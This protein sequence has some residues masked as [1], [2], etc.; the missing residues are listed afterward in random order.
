MYEVQRNVNRNVVEDERFREYV[1]DKVHRIGMEKPVCSKAT[2]ARR[3]ID[4][5]RFHCATHIS[6][7][8][9]IVSTRGVRPR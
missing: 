6:E 8:K 1:A 5:I 7:F 9:G 2:H 4:N 3:L